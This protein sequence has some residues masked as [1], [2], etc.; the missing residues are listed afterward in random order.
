MRQTV[1]SPLNLWRFGEVTTTL[2]EWALETALPLCLRCLLETTGFFFFFLTAMYGISGCGLAVLSFRGRIQDACR[3]VSESY[4]SLNYSLLF[5]L[6]FRVWQKCFAVWHSWILSTCLGSCELLPSSES[7]I[8]PWYT[9][10]QFSDDSKGILPVC[11]VK[12]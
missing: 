8:P 3:A 4:W 1:S 12:L 9:P 2:L 10:F 11:S 7:A 5:N 6:L